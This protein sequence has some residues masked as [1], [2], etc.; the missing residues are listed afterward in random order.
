[1][2]TTN[3]LFEKKLDF[4]KSA[5][6][7]QVH[8]QALTLKQQAQNSQQKSK[9]TAIEAIK[10]HSKIL[11]DAKKKELQQ[12]ANSQI[13]KA[14]V[15]C[16]SQYVQNRNDHI[17]KLFVSIT[18]HLAAFTQSPEYEDYLLGTIKATV[19]KTP[20]PFAHIGLT[21]LDMRFGEKITQATG[22]QPQAL[23]QDAIGGFVLLNQDKTQM[24]DHSFISRIQHAKGAFNYDKAS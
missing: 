18:A 16:I 20:I 1:M 9:S 22:L 23:K 13:A 14:R 2:Q 4:F 19:K 15:A 21:P 6:E 7:K 11:I 17:S 12:Q 24:L 8:Q 5:M 3:A 10:I